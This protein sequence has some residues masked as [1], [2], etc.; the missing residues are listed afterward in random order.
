MKALLLA[1]LLAVP[2]SAQELVPDSMI[3]RAVFDGHSEQTGWVFTVADPYHTITQLSIRWKFAADAG[4]QEWHHLVR[5]NPTDFLHP[6]LIRYSVRI[7]CDAMQIHLALKD[8]RALVVEGR[9]PPI[10]RANGRR[11]SVLRGRG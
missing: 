2:V 9:R 3:A 4:W 7:E 5:S 8:G 6:F 10:R 11:S 1:L